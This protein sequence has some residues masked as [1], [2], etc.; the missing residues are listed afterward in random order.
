MQPVKSKNEV[1]VQKDDRT[2][3]E[4]MAKVEIE[5][6]EATYVPSLGCWKFRVEDFK[7]VEIIEDGEPVIVRQRINAKILE[8]TEAEVDGL[9]AALGAIDSSATFDAHLY[10]ATLQETLTNPIY[11]TTA[12]DW[13]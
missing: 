5:I 7:L 13:E 11:S 10:A 12:S 4:E 2:G 3:A 6:T 9:L 1:L 8:K